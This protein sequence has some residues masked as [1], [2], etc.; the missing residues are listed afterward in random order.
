MD[1]GL[2]MGVRPRLYY[3]HASTFEELAEIFDHGFSRT[4]HRV[5]DQAGVPPQAVVGNARKCKSQ[6]SGPPEF[7]RYQGEDVIARCEARCA[8]AGLRLKALRE[9]PDAYL[10][11]EW[12]RNWWLADTHADVGAVR[13]PVQQTVAR[14]HRDEA[15]QVLRQPLHEPQQALCTSA[16]AW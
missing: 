10:R 2:N 5:D 7:R 16:A 13:L 8:D 1:V 11:D 14:D 12:Y 9:Q 6:C 4:T 3:D 15:G